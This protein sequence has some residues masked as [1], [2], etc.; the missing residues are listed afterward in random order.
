MAPLFVQTNGNGPGK[1]T[2]SANGI[3]VARSSATH[4]AESA[5][6]GAFDPG[7]PDGRSAIVGLT[8]A[9]RKSRSPL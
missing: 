7:A 5:S 8:T 2:E 3:G 1:K 4:W 9:V 6:N